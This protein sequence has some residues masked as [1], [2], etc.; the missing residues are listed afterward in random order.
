MHST[1]GVLNFTADLIRPLSMPA[2]GVKKKHPPELQGASAFFP[3]SELERKIISVITFNAALTAPEIAKEIGVAP[4]HVRYCL[5]KLFSRN[6]LVFEPFVNLFR[7]GFS[8]YT[9]FFSFREHGH[10]DLELVKRH[11]LQHPRVCWLAHL[12]GMFKYGISI[13]ARDRE[14]FLTTWESLQRRL[15]IQSGAFFGETVEVLSMTHYSP[16]N[17][18]GKNY[19]YRQ[20]EAQNTGAIVNIDAEDHAILA[21]LNSQ[22]RLNFQKIAAGVQLSAPAVAY[23]IRRLQETKVLGAFCYTAVLREQGYLDYACLIKLGT[24][25][26]SVVAKLHR[27]PRRCPYV[28]YIIQ[29]QGAWDFE[30][31]I[32][33]GTSEQLAD[34]HSEIFNTLGAQ[35]QDFRLVPVFK[36]MKTT[37]Y[38]FDSYQS[39]LSDS[40]PKG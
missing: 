17:R 28:M 36:F 29:M 8:I 1:C 11:C 22:T 38:P 15:R 4:H 31:G 2:N 21:A 7:L 39:Y 32:Q 9:V 19:V 25:S 10:G 16:I 6:L 18:P 34:V 5:K 37:K 13:C 33:T 14:G 27:M 30:I 3:F 20:I 24:I 40:V 35:I 26:R 12:G 23:R